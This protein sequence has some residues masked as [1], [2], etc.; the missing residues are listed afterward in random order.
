LKT[1]LQVMLSVLN[2]AENI[3]AKRESFQMSLISIT[4][5]LPANRDL[6]LK[7]QPSSLQR[8]PKLRA[9]LLAQERLE[10]ESLI[11]ANEAAVTEIR[12]QC[13]S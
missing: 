1:S 4:V 9:S 11:L 8:T 10:M 3:T 5:K 7:W 6:C 13:E 12:K 2:F